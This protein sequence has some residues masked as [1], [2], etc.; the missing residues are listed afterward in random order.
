[1]QEVNITTD[2]L[3]HCAYYNSKPGFN[4]YYPEFDY[5][6]YRQMLLNY[7]K[8]FFIKDKFKHTK[9]GSLPISSQST[10]LQSVF[11]Y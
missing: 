8:S 10:K 5:Y 6:L 1:M 11:Y 7:P 9:K 2:Q 3:V 4:L